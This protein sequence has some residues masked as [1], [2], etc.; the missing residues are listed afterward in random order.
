MKRVVPV[1]LVGLLLA[2]PASANPEVR[3]V[4]VES[5]KPRESAQVVEPGDLD[6]ADDARERW[7]A[8]VRWLLSLFG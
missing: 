7:E 4:V 2:G 6:D 3:Q 5:T 1:L 8:F